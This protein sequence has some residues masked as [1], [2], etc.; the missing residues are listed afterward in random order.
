MVVE[1]TVEE[2]ADAEKSASMCCLEAS[3]D[4]QEFMTFVSVCHYGV[5]MNILAG[6]MTAL[7]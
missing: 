5:T 2:E 3:N 6:I 7:A 4:T 1:A